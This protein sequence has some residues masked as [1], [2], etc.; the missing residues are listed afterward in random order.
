MHSRPAGACDLRRRN[1][2][3]CDFWRRR[4]DAGAP[5]PHARDPGKNAAADKT[6]HLVE[7]SGLV[8]DIHMPAT[9]GIE[10]YKHL[11]EA[12]YTIPTILVTAY[13]D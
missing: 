1:V 12:G 5:R 13:P 10:L 6:P 2:S 7:T 11:A 4:G 3:N 8:A 9:I